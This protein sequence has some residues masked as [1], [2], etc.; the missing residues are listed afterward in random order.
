MASPSTSEGSSRVEE[1]Y[2]RFNIF[3]LCAAFL[4][5]IL[6]GVTI[7]AYFNP[8]KPRAGLGLAYNGA[9]DL[10]VAPITTNSIYASTGNITQPRGVRVTPGGLVTADADGTLK[11]LDRG[12]EGQV[13]KVSGD[14]VHWGTSSLPSGLK[15]NEM[16]VSN[17]QGDLVPIAAP[18]AV[19]S[20]LWGSTAGAPAWAP[21]Y[22]AQAF[23]DVPYALSTQTVTN[24]PQFTN[25]PV[26][27]ASGGGPIKWDIALPPTMVPRNNAA[28]PITVPVSGL[29]RVSGTVQI[30][31]ATTG[32]RY[33]LFVE[34]S[35]SIGP[36]SPIVAA[37]E[38][39]SPSTGIFNLSFSSMLLHLPA[40]TSIGFSVYNVTSN[41]TYTIYAGNTFISVEAVAPAA[42]WTP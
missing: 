37:V 26:N 13:L 20:K 21:A 11:V 8:T 25:T 14:T 6:L 9:G 10:Q 15:A 27:F 34:T 42:S 3:V 5:V 40:G 39:L 31:I 18:N 24:P 23:A 32:N 4:F 16:V 41:A 36:P 28:F 19:A 22:V 1:L 12:S 7:G 30:N 38:A 29:Y 35:P 2:T 33:T 17:A